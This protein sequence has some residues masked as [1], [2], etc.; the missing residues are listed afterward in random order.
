MV[1]LLLRWLTS[2]VKSRCRLQAENLVLRHQVNILRRRASRR[3]RLS[4]ADR[5]A[6]VWLYRL[7]PSVVDAVAIIKP[8]TLI[9]WHRGGFKAFWRW[10]SRSRGGRPA[11]PREIRDLI[12]E[13]N[14][15]NGLWGAPRIHGELLKLGIEVAQSTVAKYMIKRPGR[16]GQSWTTFLR[17][18][19]AGIAAVDMF[20]VPTIGFKLLYC[21]VFLTHGRRELVHHAV[22]VHPTAEWVVQQMTEAFPW[23]TAPRYLVRD[24][25]AVYGHVVRRRLRGL[26]IR[27]R[28]TAPRSPWQNAYVERLIGSIRRECIDHVIILGEAHLRRIMS[29]YAGYYKRAS[30]HPSVYVLEGISIVLALEIPAA[31]RETEG[32][33]GDPP[34]DPDHEYG[35]PPLGRAPHSR[36][37]AQA[38]HR[39]RPDE[40][41]KVHDQKKERAITRLEDVSLQSRCRHRLD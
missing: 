23:D 6:F 13:M 38:W 35:Q 39:C 2:L 11:I 40:R 5:L 19:A 20:V 31:W 36:R 9:R 8:E 32:S 27:D 33:G 1:G 14:R 16:P 21:L 10:K 34:V 37:V 26:G 12:R 4:N 17:N 15:A 29:R 25:D 28:P 41:C 30:Q 7:C 3:L 22:T 18:H 24:R